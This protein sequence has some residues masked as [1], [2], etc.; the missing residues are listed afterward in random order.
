MVQPEL[1]GI[2]S[3]QHAVE[4]RLAAMQRERNPK[5]V[6]ILEL[7]RSAG[8]V[9]MLRDEISLLLHCPIQSVTFPVLTLIRAGELVK[10]PARRNTRWGSPAVVLVHRDFRPEGGE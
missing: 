6:L 9:G 7:V 2:D 4:T 8:Y 1:P 10:T 5:L 3:D